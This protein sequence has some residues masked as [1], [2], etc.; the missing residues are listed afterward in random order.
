MLIVLIIVS[1]LLAGVFAILWFLSRTP[2][3]YRATDGYIPPSF[4]FPDTFSENSQLEATSIHVPDVFNESRIKADLEVLATR[5]TLLAQYIAQ[6]ELRFTQAQQMAVLRRWTEFYKVGKEVITAR[7]DLI[8]AHHDF[9]HINREGQIK[10]KEKDVSLAR[11]DAE[12]EEVELRKAQARHARENLGKAPPAPEPTVSAEERRILNRAK[13]ED[14]LS[15][16]RSER[17]RITQSDLTEEE[18]FRMLNLIDD[19]IADLEEKLSEY[20]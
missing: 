6:A 5:P 3:S 19:R 8:R 12:L 7:T 1:F 9:L 16:L 4:Q 13:T 11:L 14:E 17:L 15:R 20:L 2:H 10:V 18:K